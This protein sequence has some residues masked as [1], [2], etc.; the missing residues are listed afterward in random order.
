M[1][2]PQTI[3]KYITPTLQRHMIYTTTRSFLCGAGLAYTVSNEKY[4]HIPLIVVIPS[5]YTGYQAYMN[6]NDIAVWFKTQTRLIE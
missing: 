3:V 6:R 4:A 1:T 2:I 5:V